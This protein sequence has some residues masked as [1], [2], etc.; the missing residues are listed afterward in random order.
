MS[1]RQPRSWARDRSAAIY[2]AEG[3]GRLDACSAESRGGS[4]GGW[5]AA[6]RSY[7]AGDWENPVLIRWFGL[8]LELGS[9]AGHAFAQTLADDHVA[10]L[11]T[12]DPKPVGLGPWMHNATVVVDTGT[13]RAFLPEEPERLASGTT[14]TTTDLMHANRMSPR[15]VLNEPSVLFGP[16]ESKNLAAASLDDSRF[17]VV[18]KAPATRPS[19]ERGAVA[20]VLLG[21]S[22][23]DGHRV[24]DNCLVPFQKAPVDT[25]QLG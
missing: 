18:L 17:G 25:L 13:A 10:V 4:L 24:F 21:A 2:R 8:L 14:A 3:A 19:L 9:G 1:P 11:G 20:N 6:S 22:P 15:A 16:L 5:L 7:R 23:A 12:T